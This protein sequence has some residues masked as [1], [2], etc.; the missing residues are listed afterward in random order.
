MKFSCKNNVETK[1]LDES[2]GDSQGQQEISSSLFSKLPFAPQQDLDKPDMADVH[3]SGSDNCQWHVH[4]RSV[5]LREF[6]S[7]SGAQDATFEAESV[8]CTV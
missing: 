2:L 7:A 4:K 6:S 1:L 5:F 8:T 3:M